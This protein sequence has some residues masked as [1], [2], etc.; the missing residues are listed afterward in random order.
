MNHQYQQHSLVGYLIHH[1]LFLR[2]LLKKTSAAELEII[3]QHEIA[4]VRNYDPLKK[5][6]F[7]FLSAYFT[8]NVKEFINIHDVTIYGARC[9]FFLC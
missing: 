2:A 7:S 9:R 1:A 6:L 4:H 5:W 8:N 3:I